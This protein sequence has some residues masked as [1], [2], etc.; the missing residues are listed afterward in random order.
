M[1]F[2][3][4]QIVLTFTLGQGNFGDSGSNVRTVTGLRISAKITKTAGAQQNLCQL[5]IFGL[6]P[7]VYNTLTA[8]YPITTVGY[9]YNTVQMQA[10]D[11]GHGT[12]P[13][14]FV[15]QI[16]V[17]Q[18]DLNSQPD[19]V[20]NV[21]AQSGMLQKVQPIDP[22]S[23]PNGI[24]VAAVLQNLAG[25]SLPPLDFVSNGVTDQLPK[26][27][28]WGTIAQQMDQ[29]FR[30]SGIGHT[31]D[32]NSLII[33]PKGQPRKDVPTVPVVSY[34]ENMIGYPS[35]STI[36]IG[37]KC[38]FDPNIVQGGQVQV[39]SSLDVAKLNGLW[40]VYH[41]VHTLESMMPGGAWM[42]ECQGA[43]YQIVGD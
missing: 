10:G 36:G 7:T 5:R 20:M 18:I 32:G 2:A 43:N 39:V 15:G 26:S 31:I 33:W 17:A 22:S 21:I 28:F 16:T 25:L 23:Y 4:K 40:Y 42:T 19:V 27:Y 41:I 11:A 3:D 1:T 13:T 8:I 14:V 29:V 38:Y 35:Y 6:S 34:Q 9:Q 37:L 24:A 30:A 12:L